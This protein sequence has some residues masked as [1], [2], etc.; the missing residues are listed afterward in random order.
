MIA[1]E[2]LTYAYGESKEPVLKDLNLRIEDGTFTLIV[3]ATGSGKSTFLYSLNGL[4]PHFFGGEMSGRVT[5]NGLS[6]Q[7]RPLR[8]ISRYV[9]TVFQNPDMQI[10]MLRVEDEVAFGCENLCLPRE[11]T[12]KRRDNALK[13]LGLRDIRGKETFKLSG[14]QKQRLIIS[15]VYA[16]GPEVYLFDEPATDIDEEGRRDLIAVFK[17]LKM[18]KKTII[19]AE[20]QYEDFIPLVDKI[21]FMENGRII[22]G[23]LRKLEDRHYVKTPRSSREPVIEIKDLYFEYERNRPALQDVNLT[24]HKGEIVA[25]CGNNGSGKTTLVKILMGLLKQQKG[26]SIILGDVHPDL[27][28]L[29]GR[30]GFL[31]QNPD[32][33]LFANTVAEEVDFGPRHLGRMINVEKY[34]EL[35]DFASLR[36][37]HPQT[38]SRGQRQILAVLSILAMEPEILILD[39]PTTGLDHENWHRLFLVLKDQALMGKTVIFTTHNRKARYFAERLIFL[40]KGRIV[41]DEVSG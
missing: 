24:I 27:D 17:K 10:F 18:E 11:E 36:E 30:V 33:Q 12:V 2:N 40:E 20:H 4:I 16:M 38:L 39:E 13:K 26:R 34:L 6:P 28:S 9:G 22:E 7:D 19:L 5:V 35:A 23:G 25:I 15:S 32:E 29:V 31:F 8:E 3:G 14:G 1:I 21:L 37:R 41:S